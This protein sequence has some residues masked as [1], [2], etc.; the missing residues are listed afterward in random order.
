VVAAVASGIAAILTS[1]FWKNGTVLAAA[2]TPVVVSVIKEALHKPLQSDAVR[3]SATSARRVVAG[4][5]ATR[6]R[7]AQARSPAVGTVPTPPPPPSNGSNGELTQG[8]VLLTHPR[9]TYGAGGSRAPLQKHW[10]VAIVTGLL[11]FVVAAV[12]L[13]VPE[14][15]FGSAV[16]SGHRTTIFGGGKSESSQKKD[17]QKT[18]TDQQQ[19]SPQG[20]TTPQATPSQ[21]EQT[22]SQPEQTPSQPQQSPSPSGGATP[23][24]APPAPTP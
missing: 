7:S 6:T 5:A 4:G 24:P 11:A 18:T 10:K 20:Q 16:S 9:R 23:A 2:M 17:E 3:R 12:V 15:L 13:T 22:P 14:L 21:P 19:Q 1:H 8:D